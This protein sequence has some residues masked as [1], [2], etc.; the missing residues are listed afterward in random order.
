MGLPT[1]SSSP[2]GL[3]EEVGSNLVSSVDDLSY[4]D[5]VFYSY[6]GR[7][8]GHVGIYVGNGQLMHASS[9]R[10]RVVVTSVTYTNGHIAAI[11]RP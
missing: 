6:G 9:S 10:G 5:L 7:Y 8:P 4:G 1:N 3:Y 2:E 11:C